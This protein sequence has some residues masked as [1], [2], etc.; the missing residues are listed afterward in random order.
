[1]SDAVQ[2]G[3]LGLGVVGGQVHRLL[4]EKAMVIAQRGG[5]AVTVRRI[6]V[7]DAAK[8]RATGVERSLITTDARDILDDPAVDVVIELIGGERPAAD[9]IRQ[10]LQAGKHV[11]T[12]NKEVMAK[13]GPLLLA[14][15]REQGVGLYYEASVGG[16]IPLIAPFRRDLV[17]NRIRSIRAILNGTTNY[18]L[19]R[20]ANGGAELGTALAEAQAAGYAEA[21]PAKDLDGMD[22]A[23]KLAILATLAYHAPVTLDVVYTEGIRGLAARD[24]RYAQEM[25]YAIKLLAIAQEQEG[26]IEARVHPAFLPAHALLAQVHGVYNAVVVEGDLTGP[27][28]FYGQG[29]GA[30]PTAS[31]VVADLIGLLKNMDREGHR[32]PSFLAEGTVSIRPMSKVH[33]RYY[34]RMPVEDRPGIL[35]EI[36]RIL[37]DGQISISSLFQRRI[38]QTARTADVVLMTQRALEEAMQRVR[39]ELSTLAVGR[40]SPGLIRVEE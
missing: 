4:T 7:R 10:A 15:A 40:E 30:A 34:L 3:L 26:T 38:D 5:R 22:A 35:A 9:Y 6:L 14:L 1:M 32:D 33:A 17:A 24:F 13:Q 23:C 19:T 29:A 37:S 31:A 18:I 21:D 11:I 12:A 16:G 28:L 27:V 36:A 8:P 20:M 2:I 25:G 39:A